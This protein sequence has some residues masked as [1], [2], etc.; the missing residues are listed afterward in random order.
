[1]LASAKLIAILKGMFRE[2]SPL[3]TF[4]KIIAYLGP[5]GLIEPSLDNNFR[6]PY[7]KITKIRALGRYSAK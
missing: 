2:D 4:H 1:M 5:K 7:V 3:I 6:P